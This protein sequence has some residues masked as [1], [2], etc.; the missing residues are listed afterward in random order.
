[1]ATS[2]I[3]V[4]GHGIALRSWAT[5]VRR[6]NFRI[7]ITKHDP[8]IGDVQSYLQRTSRVSKKRRLGGAICTPSYLKSY[9]RARK[10]STD[11]HAR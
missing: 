5:V 3:V 1:M 8:R 4:G 2:A 10:Q 9:N 11:L 6:V 7:E